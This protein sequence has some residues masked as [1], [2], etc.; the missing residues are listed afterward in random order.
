MARYVTAIESRLTPA[1][2]F[3]YLADFSHA[4]EWDP[5]VVEAS[6]PDGRGLGK[7]SRFDLV[8]KFAGRTIP[9]AY[10]IVAYDEP[11]AFVIE[12]QNPSF[13]SRDSITV[14]P[15]G[16]GSTVHYDALLVFKGVARM[17]EPLMQ[18]L[19]GRTG[20]RAAAGMRATLN[21]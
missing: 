4:A 5:S 12:A 17:L 1:E 6:S 18:L 19:F 10:E 9:M 21:P 14:S 15:R 16:E 3:A 13:T 11:R 2:A 7:G 8:V 20:D